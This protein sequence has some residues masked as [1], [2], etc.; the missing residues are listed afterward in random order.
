MPRSRSR[1][2][3]ERATASGYPRIPH[4]H[5]R[6]ETASANPHGHSRSCRH[7]WITD[8]GIPPLKGWE[9][10]KPT[11]TG[12]HIPTTHGL[13]VCVSRDKLRSHHPSTIHRRLSDSISLSRGD[14]PFLGTR[15]TSAVSNTG[16]VVY[17]FRPHSGRISRSEQLRTNPTR[18]PRPT[19]LSWT[20]RLI[21]IK[22]CLTDD[23]YR[24]TSRPLFCLVSLRPPS[25]SHA[26]RSDPA[27]SAPGVPLPSSS[28]LARD[29]SACF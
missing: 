22:R 17:C 13:R 10:V 28:I 4:P 18:P 6:A 14:S 29:L 7:C 16:R 9:E 15:T 23:C 21:K 12:R 11:H 8:G 26:V 20:G 19:H 25:D 2:L 3:R 27:E 5:S 1:S 24:M